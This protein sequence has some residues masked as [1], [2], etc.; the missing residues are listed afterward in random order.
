MITSELLCAIGGL[1]V[2]TSFGMLIYALC[3]AASRADRWKDE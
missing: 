1:I 3:C 2:G